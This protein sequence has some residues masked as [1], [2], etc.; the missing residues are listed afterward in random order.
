MS[1]STCY[2]LTDINK[3]MFVYLDFYPSVVNIETGKETR[4]EYLGMYVFPLKSRKGGFQTD[5]DRK[6]KYHKRNYLPLL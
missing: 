1:L 3:T 2:H 5:R 6:Y 4:R